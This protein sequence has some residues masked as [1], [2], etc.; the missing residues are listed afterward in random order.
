MIAVVVEGQSDV[1][2]VHAIARHLARDIAKVVVK[3]GK[4]NLDPDIAKYNRAAKQIPWV[5]FRD[6]D[7]E[8]PVE[9][10]ET[11]LRDVGELSQKFLLRLVPPMSE[12]WLMADIDNFADYFHLSKG[13]VPR[14]P[15]ALI[16]AKKTLLQLCSA[17]RSRQIRD[18]MVKAPGKV[19]PLYV[20]T[21]N[22]F[23]ANAWDVGA[24]ADRSPSLRRALERIGDL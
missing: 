5:I 19:G 4:A 2:M 15:D 13:K 16:H 22:D 17:S 8:C 24:A 23:A 6:T 14:E 10:L 1:Q 3:N 18:S 20:S 21:L 12:A 7:N 9:L 11:L